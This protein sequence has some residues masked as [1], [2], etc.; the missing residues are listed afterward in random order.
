[1]N[2]GLVPTPLVPKWWLDATPQ[3]FQTPISTVVGAIE[4]ILGD[5]SI[6]AQA[7]ECSGTE[8]HYRPVLP[9]CNAAA[10]YLQS[11][12]LKLD[13]SAWK[14]GQKASPQ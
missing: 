11:G 3:E 8:V 9:Y 5:S 13:S 4:T 14:P 6:T 1:M 7:A 10:E 2:P 12:A